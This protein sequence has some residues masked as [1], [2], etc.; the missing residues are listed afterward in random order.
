MSEEDDFSDQEEFKI[1]SEEVVREMATEKEALLKATTAA[2]GSAARTTSTVQTLKRFEQVQDTAVLQKWVSKWALQNERLSFSNTGCWTLFY[3]EQNVAKAWSKITALYRSGKLYGVVK[4]AKANGVYEKNPSSRGF[5][6]LAFTG[7]AQKE[8]FVKEVG[9]RLLQSMEYTQ[10]KCSKK[11]TREQ[12]SLSYP[13]NIY[14]KVTKK[15]KLF[16][17]GPPY[18]V[19][20]Y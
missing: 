19:L 11:F 10:Q 4:L 7:P 18:Y 9:H 20:S 8:D 13:R 17:N 15:G 12:C 1:L 3:D 2:G 6:I 16:E 14:Y 5:P